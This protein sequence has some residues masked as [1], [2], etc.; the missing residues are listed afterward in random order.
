MSHGMDYSEN[1]QMTSLVSLNSTS[2]PITQVSNPLTTKSPE[3]TTLFTCPVPI[4]QHATYDKD[5]FE[6]HM[7][8]NHPL[9]KPKFYCDI[10]AKGFTSAAN[11]NRHKTN[12]HTRNNVLNTTKS[13]RNSPNIFKQTSPIGSNRSPN[14]TTSS[15]STTSPNS[16][17]RPNS[18]KTAQKNKNILTPMNMTN[19]LLFKKSSTKRAQYKCS[20]CLL[21]FD[22]A[23]HKKRHELIGC[24]IYSMLEFDSKVCDNCYLN[25]SSHDSAYDLL[26]AH[27]RHCEYVTG[28]QPNSLSCSICKK[29]FSTVMELGQ[30]LKNF[31]K[32]C[33]LINDDELDSL[34]C[35]IC[36]TEFRSVEELRDHVF[37]EVDKCKMVSVANRLDIF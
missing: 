29:V 9:D 17:T 21:Q 4:C 11:R 5:H 8:T 27:K 13:P 26:A 37:Q 7:R 34:E 14:S 19:P 16:T 2:I 1:L 18:S 25:F 33:G 10:C 3:N 36:A 20:K 23:T 22:H 6:Q 32:Q 24:V 35:M 12:L 31:E 28:E 15:N 30:H